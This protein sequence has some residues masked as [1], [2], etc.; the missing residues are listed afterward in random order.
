[1]KNENYSFFPTLRPPQGRFLFLIGP[2]GVG[3]TTTGPHLGQQLGVPFVDLD[4]YFC[5]TVLNIRTFIAEYGYS[6]YVRQNALCFHEIV[7]SHSGNTV[8]ALSSGFLI[9]EEA[10]DVVLAN[11]QAVH[12][13]GYSVLLIPSHD[14]ATSA[15]IVARRQAGRGFGLHEEKERKKFLSRLPIYRR[16]AQQVELSSGDP[17]SVAHRIVEQLHHAHAKASEE[18]RS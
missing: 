6:E 7:Q 5:D 16:F 4:D 17:V 3:K 9:I 12:Q 8:V 1:M 11:R 14:D 18:R 15:N 13:L 10:K 2:G